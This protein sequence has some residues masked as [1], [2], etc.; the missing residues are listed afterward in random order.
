MKD[1]DVESR[2]KNI[3][4]DSVLFHYTFCY[5][6]H[7]GNL[8]KSTEDVYRAVTLANLQTSIFQWQ[9]GYDT[10]MDERGLKLSGGE[11]SCHSQSRFERF[12]YFGF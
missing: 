12:T 3:V 5:N 1:I 11:K 6:L 4:Q 2:R 10:Q 8:E 9:K 7:H